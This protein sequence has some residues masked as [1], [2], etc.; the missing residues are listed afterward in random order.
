M[1]ASNPWAED[2]WSVAAQGSFVKN[3]IARYGNKLGMARA[4]AMARQAGT[5]IGAT[6]NSTK[7]P[8]QVIVQKRFIGSPTPVAS[9]SVNPPVVGFGQIGTI[10]ASQRYT[11]AVAPFAMKL[12]GTTPSE[13]HCDVAPTDDASLTLV[14]SSS[15][16]LCTIT[17][18]AG[19]TT[20]TFNWGP[21]TTINPGD[22]LYVIGPAVADATL[23]GVNIAFVGSK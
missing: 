2:T 20:G 12:P 18:A 1:S 8:F 22:V 5:T 13:A 17:F 7:P 6:R 19:S 3:A 15:M 10:E 16:V 21:Q 4:H 14:N 23:A 9:Q 11:L